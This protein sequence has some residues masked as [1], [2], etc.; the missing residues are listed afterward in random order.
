MKT[1]PLFA[2]NSAERIAA[3]TNTKNL[4]TQLRELAE[5]LEWSCE[6]TIPLGS[7]DRCRQA[8]DEVERLRTENAKLKTKIVTVK[9]GAY[10]EAH[11]LHIAA[12]TKAR[13]ET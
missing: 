1:N 8:A 12:E 10:T 9:N 11:F 6:W 5:S 2:E 3:M 13:K 7:A 4:P